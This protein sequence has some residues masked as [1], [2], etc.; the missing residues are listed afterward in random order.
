MY[1]DHKNFTRLQS[2]KFYESL[3][4][5]GINYERERLCRTGNEE[6]KLVMCTSCQSFVSNRY[7]LKHMKMK[8]SIT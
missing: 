5:D 2:D 3:S 8:C 6:Q 7:W 4:R 1:T